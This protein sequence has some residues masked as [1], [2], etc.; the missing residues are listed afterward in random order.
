MSDRGKRWEGL[1]IV[2][3]C[4]GCT[5]EKHNEISE[6]GC[7]FPEPVKAMFCERCEEKIAVELESAI[8][9][10]TPEFFREA[11][12]L[13]IGDFC[14]SDRETDMLDV[15]WNLGDSIKD[16][17]HEMTYLFSPYWNKED[18]DA[19]KEDESLILPT[20]EEFV[21]IVQAFIDNLH[22]KSPRRDYMENDPN[23]S[24]DAMEWGFVKQL[25]EEV[26]A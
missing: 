6:W 20:P 22:P 9:E 5:E 14:V 8:W 2:C 1:P 13:A 17:S 25:F 24:T 3:D 7:S 12:D 18:Y 21:K 11:L 23:G 26:E 10:A 4:C 19:R 15:L 16:P